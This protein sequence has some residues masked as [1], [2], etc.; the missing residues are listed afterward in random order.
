MM[1]ISVAKSMNLGPMM[2]GQQLNGLNQSYD[3]HLL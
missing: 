1:H 3:G 2:A